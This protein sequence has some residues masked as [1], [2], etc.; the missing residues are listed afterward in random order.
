[1]ATRTFYLYGAAYSSD[2]TVSLDVSFNNTTVHNG[3]VTTI[4]EATP[5]DA[6]AVTMT[7]LLSFTA[8]TNV[9][10]EIP[11][12]ITVTGGDFWLGVIRANYA[13][14]LSI[15]ALKAKIQEDDPSETFL[16]QGGTDITTTATFL[17]S[18]IVELF[19][20]DTPGAD[21]KRNVL[22]D[23]VDVTEP[24]TEAN[25][26]DTRA[27]SYLVEQDETISFDQY[28]DPTWNLG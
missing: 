20:Q 7:E 3:T 25:N 4:S 18:A 8:D 26:N 22:I 6:S 2:S 10:G 15:D 28:F 13:N 17:E 14:P 5:A 24:L 11:V 16:S 23:G 1:M 12:S 21:W 27:W 19:D 9:T